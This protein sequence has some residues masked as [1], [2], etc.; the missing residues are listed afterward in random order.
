MSARDAAAAAARDLGVSKRLAYRYAQ[1]S[2]EQR[3]GDE[4]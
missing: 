2:V 3:E 1:E 4:E